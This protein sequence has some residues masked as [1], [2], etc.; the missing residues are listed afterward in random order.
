M[1]APGARSL[2]PAGE[3]H[4]GE[5]ALDDPGHLADLLP[6]DAGHRIEV[7]PQL[8]GMIQILRSHGMG[9]QL[10]AGQVGEPGQRR[11]VAGHD[12][13]R[14]ATGGE[15]EGDDLDPRRAGGR[16]ALLVE[17]LLADA[18]G[19]A[20]QHVGPAARA[21]ERAF[22]D[23]DVVVH[24]VELGVL[25][26]GEEDL[27]GIGYGDLAAGDHD[28]LVVASVLLL[29]ALRALVISNGA[30]ARWSWGARR[31]VEATRSPGA[32]GPATHAR[33]CYDG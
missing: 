27:L 13:V 28:D 3:A 11:R 9:V 14:A 4:V 18:V 20:H 17:E 30:S 7:H 22:G 33:A 23:R 15:P 16:R 25:R 6:L 26:G 5:R 24:Q 21:A 10:Q 29:E 1:N 31:A 12:F 2:G 19:I 32:S 8:V